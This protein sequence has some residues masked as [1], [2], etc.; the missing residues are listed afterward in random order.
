VSHIERKRK[1][2]DNEG[3]KRSQELHGEFGFED[4]SRPVLFTAKEEETTEKAF[5]GFA[6][7]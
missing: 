2:L 6:G 5:K 7:N 1:K 4:A 3:Y